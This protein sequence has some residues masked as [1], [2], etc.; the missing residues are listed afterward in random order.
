MQRQA[1][2]NDAD[3]DALDDQRLFPQIDLDRFEL[4]ILGQQQHQRA[5]LTIALDRDLV[6][7]ARNDDLP[8]AQ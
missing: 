7:E 5:V 4:V 8:A 3:H 1:V 2:A 6:V